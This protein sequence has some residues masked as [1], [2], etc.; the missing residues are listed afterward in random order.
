M[1]DGQSPQR[2]EDMSL[3]MLLPD[4]SKMLG[5]LAALKMQT[6]GRKHGD[7]AFRTCALWNTAGG[8]LAGFYWLADLPKE[9][10]WQ[11]PE[12]YNVDDLEVVDCTLIDALEHAWTHRSIIANDRRLDKSDPGLT[13]YSA[14]SGW[15][16]RRLR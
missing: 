8:R 15:R 7:G 2:G 13:N 1:S 14:G 11:L 3:Y 12:T 4:L 16:G 5:T 10:T 9:S 6:R